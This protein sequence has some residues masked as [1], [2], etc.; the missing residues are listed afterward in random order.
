MSSPVVKL[1]VIASL[2]ECSKEQLLRM[3]PQY[4]ELLDFHRDVVEAIKL[5][6]KDMGYKDEVAKDEDTKDTDNTAYSK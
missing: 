5:K 4:E 2:S 1:A 3:L 6:L